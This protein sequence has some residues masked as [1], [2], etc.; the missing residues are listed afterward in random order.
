MKVMK[1]RITIR[2]R[3]CEKEKA[4]TNHFTFECRPRLK[5]GQIVARMAIKALPVKQ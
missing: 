4:V 1:P 2:I 5:S 3:M